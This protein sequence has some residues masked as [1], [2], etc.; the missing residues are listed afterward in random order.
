MSRR[1]GQHFLHDPAILD[2]IVRALDPS[3]N[4]IVVEIGSGKGTLTRRLA[5]KVG[6]VVAIETD[7]VL[8]ATLRGD[9][10]G[11]E[12]PIQNVRVIQGDAL[13]LDWH[14]LIADTIGP[15]CRV[16]VNEFKIIGNIPYYI[17]APLIEK[18]LCPPLPRVAVY[19][20]QRE[21]ADRIAAE[22]GTKAFGAL[23]VGV[24][25][26]A[27][28]ERLFVVRPGSFS[29]PPS[30]DSAVIRLKPL[31]APLIMES[32]RSGFRRFVTALFGQRRKQLSRALRTITEL[33]RPEIDATLRQVGMDPSA[34]PEV[35][36]PEQMLRLFRRVNL[37]LGP[38]RSAFDA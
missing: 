8:A 23:S 7:P 18:A 19:L 12:P 3:A 14:A 15:D 27:E 31:A 35:L 32:E 13:S 33:D 25:I 2:R 4:D 36:S 17:T 29:P 9:P 1:L 38:E 26:V 21:V 28:V 24:R 10:V 37:L 5:R 22:P 6:K 20:V 34:R 30:V 11:A 16:P